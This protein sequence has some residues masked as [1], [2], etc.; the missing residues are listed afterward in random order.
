MFK[1][2]KAAAREIRNSARDGDVEELPLRIAA[3]RDSDRGI[4]YQ[5]GFDEISE[6]DTLINSCGVDI[7]IRCP[8]KEL[9]NGTVLDYVELESGQFN[10]IFMN[11]NDP[12]YQP[13][14]E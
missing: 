2:T 3:T 14:T 10:F 12:H 9:L 8:D 1:L 5:M 7:L 11:P 4:S 6:G 13:P